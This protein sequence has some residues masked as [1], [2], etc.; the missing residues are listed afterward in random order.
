MKRGRVD[1]EGSYQDLSEVGGIPA[2]QGAGISL[3]VPEGVR[4]RLASRPNYAA[5]PCMSAEL[6]E[7]QVRAC[8]AEEVLAARF[9][10]R[11]ELIY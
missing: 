8:L 3:R 9:Q 2:F 6:R 11:D 5:P 1:V 10:T 7:P 4:R